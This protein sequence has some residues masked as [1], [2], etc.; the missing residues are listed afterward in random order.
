MKIEDFTLKLEDDEVPYRIFAPTNTTKE[1][2]VLWIQGW[3][4]SMDSHREGVKRMAEQSGVTFVTM[5]PAGH[6]LHKLALDDSTRKQ[7]H[8]E[9]IAMFD[10]I[11]KLGYEKIIVIGGSFGGYMTALLCGKRPVHAAVLR[12]P[13]NY[14]DNEFEKKFNDTLRSKD[15]A[16]YTELKESD[17]LLMDS[18]ATKAVANFD[19]FVYVLEHELDEVIPAKV[20]KRYFAVAKHG[21]YLIIPKT[22]HTP[23]VM[24]DPQE[25]FAYIEQIIVSLIQ[26]INLQE[27]LG[28]E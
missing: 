9:V 25:H 15:Y 3:S 16:A 28:T 8:E 4:S 18:E 14:P 26:A 23:K 12:C 17:G 13:A 7:Q 5:D 6:G 10:E 20:P 19:G 27:G 22:K 2:C 21:N 1:W 24:K 11:K